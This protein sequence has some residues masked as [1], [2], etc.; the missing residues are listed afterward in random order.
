MKIITYEEAR[1]NY[2]KQQ[3]EHQKRRLDYAI[4]HNKSCWDCADIGDEVS[5][6]QDITE[7]LEQQMKEGK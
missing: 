5:Y 2:F 1:L 3:L 6:Y 7:M 4:A